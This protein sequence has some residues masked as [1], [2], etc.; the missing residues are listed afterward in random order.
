[1]RPPVAGPRTAVYTIILKDG[2]NYAAYNAM[3]KSPSIKTNDQDFATQ[4]HTF[5]DNIGNYPALGVTAAQKTALDDDAAYFDWVLLCQTILQQDRVAWTA[6]KNQ[7]RNGT[8]SGS[9]PA[10]SSLPAAPT[11][12]ASGI[13]TRFRSLTQTVKSNANYTEAIGQAL[14]IEGATITPPDFSS[15]APQLTATVSGNRVLVDWG[16]GGNAAFL[17]MIRLEVDRGDG[18]GFVFLANDTTPGYIDTEPFPATPKKWSY[19]GMYM[20]DDAQVG[21]WSAP[22]HVMVG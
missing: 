11:A 17:D 3:P 19:R 18:T 4:I 10:P 22:A 12:V 7:M 13:E 15:I 21:Q 8:G 5:A 14:G 9:P 16:F 2:K 1:M 20:V 6:Y